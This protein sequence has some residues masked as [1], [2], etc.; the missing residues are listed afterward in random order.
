VIEKQK[1]SERPRQILEDWNSLQAKIPTEFW[2]DLKEQGLIQAGAN[3]PA[4]PA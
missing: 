1:S 4:W 2:N 3:L